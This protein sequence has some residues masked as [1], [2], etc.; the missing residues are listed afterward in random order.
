[1]RSQ[2]V[3]YFG[4]EGLPRMRE[5]WSAGQSAYAE[6]GGLLSFSLMAC[7]LAGM[8]GLQMAYVPGSWRS[9]PVLEYAA[10]WVDEAQWIQRYGSIT[11]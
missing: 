4:L 2:A 6:A 11:W 1:M 3:R 7:G 5:R 9:V 8:A 10:L